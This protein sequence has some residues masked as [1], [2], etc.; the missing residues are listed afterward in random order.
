MTERY[1]FLNVKFTKML[2]FFTVGEAY[3]LI[4]PRPSGEHFD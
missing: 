3:G 2:S 4:Y 1:D